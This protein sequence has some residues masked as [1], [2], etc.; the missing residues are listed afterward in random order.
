M[1]SAS[2]AA[3]ADS[4]QLAAR[5]YELESVA[6]QLRE[7]S[8]AAHKAGERLEREQQRAVGELEAMHST[9]ARL[10]SRFFAAEGDLAAANARLE[11]MQRST[12]ALE[13]GLQSK[14]AALEKERECWQRTEA[15]LRS[16]LAAAK[17][18]TVTTRRQ[19]VS[20]T[21]HSRSTSLGRGI[22]FTPTM[23]PLS[24]PAALPAMP[25]TDDAHDARDRAMQA[26]I[27]QL[28]RRVRDAEAHAQEATAH[29]TRVHSEAEHAVAGLEEQ[30]RHVEQL[31]H[32]VAQLTELNESLREDNE[33]YQVLLQMSTIKGGLTFTNARTSV[34]S[35]ASSGKWAASPTIP[36]DGASPPPAAASES[37]SPGFGRDLAAEL[38]QALSLDGSDVDAHVRITELEEQTTR[39]K[40]D[41]RKARYER[42]QLGEENKALSL[43]V[44]KILG[45]IM[46]S[47]GGLEAVLS[48][49]YDALSPGSR[50]PAASSF[51]APSPTAP[52]PKHVRRGSIRLARNTAPAPKP[53]PP[54]PPPPRPPV[55]LTLEPGTG[56]GVTSVFV[57]PTSPARA[58]GRQLPGVLQSPPPYSR[59]T[60][61]ATV[62]AGPAPD[63]TSRDSNGNAAATIGAAAGSA[64]WKRMS[65][66][67]GGGWN[68]PSEPQLEAD[69]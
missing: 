61:S 16:E 45:R 55:V 10:E 1:A 6:A 28:T 11:R 67:L 12:A 17:H 64:W 39:L 68:A 19:T 60:R 40:E 49:D 15:D 33:S 36:E 25:L 8:D 56:D 24:P 21:S 41:L 43:Y 4:E 14:E 7:E 29:A 47:A 69:T 22:A 46:A 42:R 20:T 57:P 48:C 53:L 35:R 66:R 63:R 30:L 34:D 23:L 27:S 13:A 58:A 31:E 3:L 5:V 38:G 2:G 26:Q 32:A 51:A 62:A 59:R 37:A 65:I 50:P 44:N 54:P 52:P 9:H 18:R